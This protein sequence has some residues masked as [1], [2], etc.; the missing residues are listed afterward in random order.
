MPNPATEILHENT[1]CL[2]N[3]DTI[4]QVIIPDR[5][6][7]G[8]CGIKFLCTFV[9]SREKRLWISASGTRL[10]TVNFDLVSKFRLASLLPSVNIYLSVSFIVFN[11]NDYIIKHEI[12]AF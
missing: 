6:I 4:G 1:A 10:P 11:S 7:N 5:K 9:R 2:C 3:R 12:T 8:K